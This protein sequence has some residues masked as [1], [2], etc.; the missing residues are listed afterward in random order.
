MTALVGLLATLLI[1]EGTGFGSIA[2]EAHPLVWIVL[3]LATPV[4]GVVIALALARRSVPSWRRRRLLRGFYLLAYL[5]MYAALVYAAGWGDFVLVRLGWLGR[6]AASHALLA[7]PAG[8]L[9][10]WVALWS[11]LAERR[12]LSRGEREA[13]RFLPW[14]AAGARLVA[15]PAGVFAITIAAAECLT[16]IPEL[17]SF[18]DVHPGLAVLAG[19]LLLGLVVAAFPW[20]VL[21]AWPSR[22]LAPGGLRASLE[23]M[24]ARAGVAFRDVRLWERT[25]ALVNAC[26]AGHFSGSRRVFFTQGAREHL[27]DAD[28]EAV[29]A[30]EVS[31]VTSGHL[32]CYFALL[33]AYV[34]S[35]SPLERCL[36]AAPPWV[37][38]L[39]FL[40]VT[41]AVW[42]G[43]FGYLSRRLETEADIRG[44]ELAAEG[45]YVAAL[46]RVRCLLGPASSERG[47]WRHFSLDRRCE[48][49]RRALDDPE[50]RRSLLA[51]SRRLRGVCYLVLGIAAAGFTWTCS[52]D[53]F[54][55]P[56]ELALERG[57]YALDRAADLRRVL[58]ARDASPGTRAWPGWI[59]RDS[60]VIEREYIESVERVRESL[61]AIR[62][63]ERATSQSAIVEEES[64]LRAALAEHLAWRRERGT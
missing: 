19:L 10:L 3:P 44:A 52:R 18:L 46:D 36:D 13:C 16:A 51:A 2:V 45:V 26:I 41:A 58:E 33:V 38:A 39:A 56:P 40:A 60:V 50:A 23:A 28:L 22:P 25:S 57:A 37:M 17:G 1:L 63:G 5:V 61:E 14:L 49:L 29:F 20:L 64:A 31:H 43:L 32:W 11:Y 62:D 7:A 53:L 48:T 27:T 6:P 55:P 15:V 30:H 24:A 34:L 21:L 35:L 8:V 47:G 54:R 9:A 59:A 12:L 42:W 4:A